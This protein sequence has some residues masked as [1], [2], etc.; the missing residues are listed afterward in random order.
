MSDKTPKI[1]FSHITCGQSCWYARDEDCKCSCGGKNHGVL[2]DGENEQPARMRQVNGTTYYLQAVG[3]RIELMQLINSLLPTI[4]GKPNANAG[5]YDCNPAKKGNPL[6]LN[7]A[8]FAQAQKWSELSQ[9]S[10]LTK[11]ELYFES[12]ALLWR[13]A[14]IDEKL[15]D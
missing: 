4:T 8:T 3:N 13:R 6:M 1:S 11:D 10:H 12:P 14:D 9:W 7:Y 5:H 15:F 2:K